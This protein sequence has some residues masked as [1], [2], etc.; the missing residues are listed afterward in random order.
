MKICLQHGYEVCITVHNQGLKSKS[1]HVPHHLNITV[2]PINKKYCYSWTPGCHEISAIK[3]EQFS[4]KR[5]NRENRDIVLLCVVRPHLP[6][7]QPETTGASTLQP[8][9]TYVPLP[10]PT[11]DTQASTGQKSINQSVSEGKLVDW[12]PKIQWVRE[13]NELINS[14]HKQPTIPWFKLVLVHIYRFDGS[15]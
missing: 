11:Q 3:R 6:A 10:R 9:C 2:S 12:H 5:D 14:T 15:V 7:L 8:V 1:Q 13:Q 4:T